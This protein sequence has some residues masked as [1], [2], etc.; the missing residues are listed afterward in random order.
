M[1]QQQS[2]LTVIGDVGVDLVMGPIHDWPQ[3]GTETIVDRNE[4]RAGGSAGNCALAMRYMGAPC[5]LVSM[6][7]NDDFG[8][9]LAGQFD[10]AARKLPVA[11]APTSLSVG[12]IHECGERSFFTTKGHLQ[13]FGLPDVLPQLPLSVPEGSVALLCGVF[14]TPK[15]RAQY[16]DL[17]AVLKARGYSV[18][19]DTGWPPEGWDEAL[20]QEVFGWLEHCDHILLNE[21]EILNLAG[22]AALHEALDTIC[23][24]LDATATVVAKTGPRGAEARRANERVSTLSPKADIADTIGAGDSFNAGYLLAQ[25]KGAPLEDSLAAGCRAATAII[26]RFP[27]RRILPGELA[28]TVANTLAQ[29]SA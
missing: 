4:L 20:R 15:L 25:L 27:R 5:R 11:P 26:S 1:V 29:A 21:T 10:M 22:C 28:H 12:I 18:A 19:I 9:W 3:V 23:Y 6:T 17:I 7:G 13:E 24:R 2:I 16:A 8:G 14:L